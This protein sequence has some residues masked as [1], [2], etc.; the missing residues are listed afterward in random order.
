MTNIIRLV[1]DGDVHV[2][3]YKWQTYRFLITDGRTI[4]VRAVHDDSWLRAEVV[5]LAN[6]LTK[7][8]ENTKV[9]LRIEGSTIVPE[10]APP[11]PVKRA[12]K[13]LPR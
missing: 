8:T 3:D 2:A 5:K 12:T 4:D 13:K 9:E 7:Y 1:Q 10:P 6:G 11:A